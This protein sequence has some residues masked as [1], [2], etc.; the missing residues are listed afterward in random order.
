VKSFFKNIDWKNHALAMVA[1]I[2]GIFLGLSLQEMQNDNERNKQLKEYVKLIE[3]EINTNLEEAEKFLNR[4]YCYEEISDLIY[5]NYLETKLNY[6]HHFHYL[7]KSISELNEF[8]NNLGRDNFAF[9]NNESAFDGPGIPI[10]IDAVTESTSRLSILYQSVDCQ[11]QHTVW[12]SF[13]FT[14]LINQMP[15]QEIFKYSQIYQLFS[16]ISKEGEFNE[17]INRVQKV[18]NLER[19]ALDEGNQNVQSHKERVARIYKA[20]LEINHYTDV[21][22]SAIK[23]LLGKEHEQKRRRII[24]EKNL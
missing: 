24:F 13:K 21:K 3:N 4:S 17:P 10:I 1:S 20:Y 8:I 19:M 5:Y 6:V 11:F 22:V 15:A 7:N 9:L 23:A 12:E 2:I 18:L 14:D 16:M